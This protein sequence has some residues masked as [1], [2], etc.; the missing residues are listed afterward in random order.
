MDNLISESFR[1]LATGGNFILSMPNL[2]SYINRLALLLGY[3]PR[4]VEISSVYHSGILPQ[5]IGGWFGHLH[6]ATLRAMKELLALYGFR[7]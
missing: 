4:D 7:W 3:Q 6:S 2:G 1:V 5:Y